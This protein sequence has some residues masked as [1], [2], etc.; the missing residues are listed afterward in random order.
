MLETFTT[1]TF[2]GRVGETFRLLGDGRPPVDTTL[3][4]VTVLGDSATGSLVEGR[5][6]GR[7][8][9]FSL[10]FH[11]PRGVLVPQR[12]HAM[13]HDTLGAFELFLVPLGPE[14]DAMRYEAVF[15]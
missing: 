9:A 12:I 11:A 4:E 8:Q 15:T 14:G 7:R 13:E 5:T 3:A 2:A 10:V 1:E 6:G